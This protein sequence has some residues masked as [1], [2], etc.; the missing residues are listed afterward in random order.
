MAGARQAYADALR[1]HPGR[2]DLWTL[3]VG[4]L[5]PPRSVHVLRRATQRLRFWRRRL[6]PAGLERSV[7]RARASR[8][9]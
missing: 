9:S 1:Q 2:L 7:H 8:D 5:L 3:Y 6:P 4:L